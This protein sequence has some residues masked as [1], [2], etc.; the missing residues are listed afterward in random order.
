ML[1]H[2]PLDWLA[3]EER[4]PIQAILAKHAATYLHGHLHRAATNVNEG[5]GLLF[6]A[7]QAGA[8]FQARESEVW[9]NRILF[10]GLNPDLK[11]IA[12]SPFSWNP[13]N[14]EWS[15]DGG[16]LPERFRPAG[17]DVW[18]L[19]SPVLTILPPPQQYVPPPGWDIINAAS[20]A[21]RQIA[22][23]ELDE[24]FI[25]F[26]DGAPP[27]W[28]TALATNMPRRA[29]VTEVVSAIAE[30]AAKCPRIVLLIGAGGEG[31][32]T[33]FLQSIHQIAMAG[34]SV[35]WRHDAGAT[36]DATQ[37]RHL[38]SGKWL[39]ATDDA[40]RHAN[41]LYAAAIA[42]RESQRADVRFLFC[43]RDTD[44][45]DVRGQS[46]WSGF[47]GFQE[48]RLRG[49]SLGDAT[50][51]VSA[52]T[53]LGSRGLGSLQGLERSKAAEI[54]V[55]QA[56]AELAPNE[57]AFLGAMLR[58][59]IGTGMRD[60]V[61][62]I[63][64]RL[65]RRIVGDQGRSLRDALAFVAGMQNEG[66]DFLTPEVL[67]K[68]MGCELRF[69][70]KRILAPLGEEAAAVAAGRLVVTRHASIAKEVI[71]ILAEDAEFDVDQMFVDLV[72]A[73]ETTYRDGT[74]MDD[75]KRWRYFCDSFVRS[76][77]AKLGLRIEQTLMRFDPANAFFVTKTSSIMRK[78]GRLEQATDMLRAQRISQFDKSRRAWLAEWAVVE[79]QSLSARIA[80][81]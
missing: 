64:T 4:G 8:A 36:I 78:M 65:D 28:K 14:R 42:I 20:L 59:R 21:Q 6:R 44:W 1:G 13:T 38:P 76:G 43:A 2:H 81:S 45:H 33:A 37:L 31:K 80:R 79:G 72:I 54:L 51:I 15:L 62:S 55:A 71:A 77:R 35:L 17:T 26:F 49:L 50:Q 48:M 5:A 7:V 74:P 56:K 30:E 22:G 11:T 16:D 25:K 12:V 68:A 52:W 73:A 19:P 40:D 24:E 61:R 53:V 75:I 9:R 32:S 18:E 57:G 29:I 3:D 10:C 34:W 67:A 69:F 46:D 66:A 63:L 60:H 23:A 41:H 47:P 70:K 58:T 39:I 27:T